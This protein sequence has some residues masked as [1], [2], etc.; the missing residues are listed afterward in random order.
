LAQVD[1]CDARNVDASVEVDVEH[2]GWGGLSS[3]SDSYFL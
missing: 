2:F 1:G 3:V